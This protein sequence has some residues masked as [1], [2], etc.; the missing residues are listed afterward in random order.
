M[1]VTAKSEHS[2]LTNQDVNWFLFDETLWVTKYKEYMQIDDSIAYS[3]G[4]FNWLYESNDTVLFHKKDAR[5]ETAVIGLSARIKLG[6]ADKYIN[7]ICKGKMGNLYYA[8]N[9]NIDFVFS[10]AFIYD[11]NQDLLLSFPD[12]FSHKKDH[13]LFITEDF[14]FVI[15]DHQLKGWVLQRASRH[16]CIHRERNM[17]ITPH[18]IARYLSA[19]D[20]WEKEEEMTE[21]ESL[22]AAC[23]QEGGVFYEALKE[24]MMNLI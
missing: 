9:K 4:S 6:F 5:F 19:L 23:K 3:M 7:Y 24:C 21:L 8:E 15:I 12:N 11:E 22:L 16:V 18:M 2:S 1:N 14:G 17:G 20:V 10:P 13:V